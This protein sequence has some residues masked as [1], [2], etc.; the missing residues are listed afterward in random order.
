MMNEALLKA[1]LAVL[2]DG[3]AFLYGENKRMMAELY[4]E[5]VS[6]EQFQAWMDEYKAE[7][8]ELVEKVVN[9]N[10]P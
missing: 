1:T 4:G 3:Q 9:K 7:S 6:D 2:L 10:G 8:A 5:D